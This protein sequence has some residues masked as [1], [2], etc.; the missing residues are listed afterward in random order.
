VLGWVRF[1]CTQSTPCE[2]DMWCTLLQIE[3]GEADLEAC[4]SR[5]GRRDEDEVRVGFVCVRAIS[6]WAFAVTERGLHRWKSWRRH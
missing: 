5:R 1:D 4:T 6:E 2:F 3:E